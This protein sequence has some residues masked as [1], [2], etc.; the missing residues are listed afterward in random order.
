MSKSGVIDLRDERSQMVDYMHHQLVGPLGGVDEELDGNPLDRYLL[1][2]LYPQSADAEE[3]QKEEESDASASAEEETEVE[4]PISMAFERLPASMGIS[5]YVEGT[6][7]IKVGVW[8]GIYHL[9]EGNSQGAL[10]A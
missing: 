3:V 6:D 9:G 2:V 4:N 8:G 10:E 7:R 5:F 1:G